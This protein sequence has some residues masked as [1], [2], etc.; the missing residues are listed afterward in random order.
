MNHAVLHSDLTRLLELVS[1][2]QLQRGI[3]LALWNYHCLTRLEVGI[4]AC[5]AESFEE[6]IFLE[7]RGNQQLIVLSDFKGNQRSIVEKVKLMIALTQ[8]GRIPK[9][10]LLAIKPVTQL[11]HRNFLGA[12]VKYNFMALQFRAM[13]LL[14]PFKQQKCVCCV[15][16]KS[17]YKTM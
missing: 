13:H 11:V 14:K 17:G 12:L 9:S 6:M 10:Q 16:S 5:L 15:P 7:P 8:P 4:L 3:Q 2:K 1:S